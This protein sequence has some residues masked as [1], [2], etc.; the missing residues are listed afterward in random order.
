MSLNYTFFEI[1]FR[2]M[3]NS[4]LLSV[5]EVLIAEEELRQNPDLKIILN[6]LL[7]SNQISSSRKQNIKTLI[8]TMEGIDGKKD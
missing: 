3:D 6:K 8:K 1:V 4:T 7:N 5:I 2:T